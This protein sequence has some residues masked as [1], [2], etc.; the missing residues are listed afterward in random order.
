MEHIDTIL[1]L[2]TH[3]ML[4]SVNTHAAKGDAARGVE[5]SQTLHVRSRHHQYEIEHLI[6]AAMMMM[7]LR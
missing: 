7:R 2:V 5:P 6:I 4:D 1:P 3:N